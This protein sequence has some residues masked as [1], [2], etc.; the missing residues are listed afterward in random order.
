MASWGYSSEDGKNLDGK[1][2]KLFKELN[3]YRILAILA[4]LT[5]VNR[6]VGS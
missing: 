5:V 4:F 1:V 2:K 3:H 6:K